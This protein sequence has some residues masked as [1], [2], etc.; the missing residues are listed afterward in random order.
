MIVK[1]QR[2]I[3]PPTGPA[4]VYNQDRSFHCFTPMNPELAA[5]ME[6]DPKAYFDVE[7]VEGTLEIGDRV[8]DQDW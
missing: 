1:I 3:V 7:M 4:L 6:G 5:R 2:A 8:R